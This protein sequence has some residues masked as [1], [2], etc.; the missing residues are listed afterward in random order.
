[1]SYSVTYVF[2][3]G[4]TGCYSNISSLF[5]NDKTVE[6]YRDMKF[7]ASLPVQSLVSLSVEINHD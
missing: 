4:T 2:D 7:Y 1:M 3:D 5:F 6:I